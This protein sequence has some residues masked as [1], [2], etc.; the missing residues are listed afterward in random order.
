MTASSKY[1]APK[2]KKQLY[3]NFSPQSDTLLLADGC[4]LLSLH[5]ASGSEKHAN[6]RSPSA[7]TQQHHVNLNA[8]MALVQHLGGVGRRYLSLLLLL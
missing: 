3:I 1:R 8:K 5:S 6:Q 2:K 4:H 7:E